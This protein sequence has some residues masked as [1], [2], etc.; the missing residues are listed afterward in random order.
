LTNR[1]NIKISEITTI[2]NKVNELYTHFTFASDGMTIKSSQNATKTVKLDNDSLDFMDNNT[3]VAQITDKQ[4]LITDA[5]V[6]KQMKIGNITIKPSG[7]GGIM[8]IYE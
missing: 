6:K 1:I 2:G 4:L 3:V 7:V 5:E 8:F